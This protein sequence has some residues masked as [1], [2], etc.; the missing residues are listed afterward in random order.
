MLSTLSEIRLSLN[1]STLRAF[2]GH[3]LPYLGPNPNRSF[4]NSVYGPGV[5]PA[6]VT[7]RQ[8]VTDFNNSQALLARVAS[9]VG[10]FLKN[11]VA[12][13]PQF[14]KDPSSWSL[15]DRRGVIPWQQVNEFGHAV[16]SGSF[17]PNKRRGIAADPVSA[18][19]FILSFPA[20]GGLLVPNKVY[21]EGI[22]EGRA[23]RRFPRDVLAKYERDIRDYTVKTYKEG[24]LLQGETVLLGNNAVQIKDHLIMEHEGM[25]VQFLRPVTMVNHVFYKGHA[26]WVTVEHPDFPGRSFH[27]YIGHGLSD[28]SLGF[29][30]GDRLNTASGI[31]TFKDLYRVGVMTWDEF[32]NLL[33]RFQ[34]GAY[35]LGLDKN[36]ARAIDDLIRTDDAGLLYDR[37]VLTYLDNSVVADFIRYFNPF[38]LPNCFGGGTER[39]L[40]EAPA[41]AAAGAGGPGGEE[42]DIFEVD[43]DDFIDQT[44]G[45]EM[46]AESDF[47]EILESYPITTT[48]AEGLVHSDGSPYTIDSFTTMLSMD[49]TAEYD[50]FAQKQGDLLGTPVDDAI[51]AELRPQLD[52]WLDW[53]DIRESLETAVA[54]QVNELVEETSPFADG[55]AADAVAE[56][57]QTV[58]FGE[59]ISTHLGEALNARLGPHSGSFR[60]LLDGVSLL[61]SASPDV[62]AMLRDYPLVDALA[63]RV[64]SEMTAAS[65]PGGSYLDAQTRVSVIEAKKEYFASPEQ[66][67]EAQQAITAAVTDL[68]DVGNLEPDLARTAGEIHASQ[69]NLAAVNERLLQTPDDKDLQKQ[70]DELQR[71][72]EQQVEEQYELERKQA[73][74]EELKQA[75]A[76]TGGETLDHEHTEAK[77]DRDSS[78]EHVFGRGE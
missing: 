62:R 29:N 66:R 46:A 14:G 52:Q 39:F 30:V 75:D 25:T 13:Y 60:S 51:M 16:Y 65:E 49:H 54:N 47:M 72:I 6:S 73:E 26:I 35:A 33:A 42:C 7:P 12:S 38:T 78:A 55:S 41:A 20:G 4:L 71:Q 28:V 11:S 77:H 17:E 59:G 50:V 10:E 70:R 69:E 53:D 27:M 23:K 43:L 57:F 40:A 45:K 2:G 3:S 31:V 22:A 19:H 44:E 8:I 37:R 74:S 34:D 68:G 76:E 21:L 63:S 5:D 18:L 24:R 36:V 32:A 15:G 67:A 58:E 64:F 48:K 9:F 56:R 1:G 61:E